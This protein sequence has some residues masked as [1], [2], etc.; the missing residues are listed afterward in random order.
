MRG[1]TN[2][3]FLCGCLG[4]AL[5]LLAACASRESPVPSS[6]MAMKPPYLPFQL[7][8]KFKPALVSV[9]DA[10]FVERLSREIGVNICFVRPMSA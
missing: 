7:I 9:V 5:V 3:M 1:M 2:R 8:V 4:A 10:A 6:P